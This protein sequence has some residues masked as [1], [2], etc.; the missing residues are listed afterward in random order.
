MSAETFS[1]S[2]GSG[3][4]SIV[5]DGV[6]CREDGAY[7]AIR[8]VSNNHSKT[9]YRYVRIGEDKYYPDD[10][11]QFVIPVVLGENMEIVGMTAKMSTPHEIT[12]TIFV[13]LEDTDIPGLTFVSA[14]Q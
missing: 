14:S 8:F 6:E 7:A 5:C 1:F 2:G 3:R 12:Y 11:G 9:D 13:Q 4:V 10:N